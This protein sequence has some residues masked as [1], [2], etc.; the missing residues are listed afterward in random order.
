VRLW[1]TSHGVAVKTFDLGCPV[2]DVCWAPYSSTTFAAVTDDGKAVVFDLAVNHHGPMC[3]QKV[4][5]KAKATKLAFNRRA[6]L[7]LVGDAAGGVTS[8]KLSP[9]LRKLTPIPVPP[10]KKVRAR[11]RAGGQGGQGGRVGCCYCCY[12]TCARHPA[13]CVAPLRASDSTRARPSPLRV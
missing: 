13:C 2:G 6:P 10:F 1:D 8:F 7:L 3:E 4:V 5:K 9:N 12:C 11:A